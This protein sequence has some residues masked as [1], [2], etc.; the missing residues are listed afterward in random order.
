[1]IIPI[2][3]R[4]PKPIA[5]AESQRLLY[6]GSIIRI[7]SRSNVTWASE[8]PMLGARLLTLNCSVIY[9]WDASPN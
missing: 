9:P 5:E 3:V 8:H 7:E 6:S 4:H 1:M 2:G